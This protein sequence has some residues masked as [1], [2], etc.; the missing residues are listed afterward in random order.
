MESHLLTLNLKAQENVELDGL[1][2]YV[3]CVI[4]L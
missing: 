1:E 2:N 3:Y 4:S